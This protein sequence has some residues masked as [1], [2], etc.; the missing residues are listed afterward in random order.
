DAV[1]QLIRSSPSAD[2]ART[3]L[4]ELLDIDEVQATAILDMQ[5]RR[6]AALERQKIL[7]DLAKAEEEIAEFKAILASEERQRTIIRDELA[8]IVEKYGDERRSRIIPA[9]GDL[10]AEDLIPEEPV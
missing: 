4:M 8:E 6:L 10:T 3:G 5:L 1:I 9:E 2:Q 7:D